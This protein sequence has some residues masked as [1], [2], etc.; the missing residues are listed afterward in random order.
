MKPLRTALPTLLLANL[1][2][3]APHMRRQTPSAVIFTV[4]NF[5]AFFA[6]TT[7]EDA[8]S[9]LTFHVADTRPGL[10]AEADCVI[11]NT[12][13]NLYAI[14][15]LFDYC[16]ARALDVSYRF[17]ETGLT[18]R[19]GWSVNGTTYMTGSGTQDTYWT[20]EGPGANV[21]VHPNGKLYARK[22]EWLFP[23]TRLQ[24]GT[25]P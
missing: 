2:L 4:T 1:S 18:V 3:A 15:A 10:E 12:Y 22:E 24:P 25:P 23:V 5:A 13:F 9:N 21:T 8:Q 7:L 17:T 19:R 16:G 6:D 14:S 11:P 20:E